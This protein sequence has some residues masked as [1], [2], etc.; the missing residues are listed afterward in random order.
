[1]FS[2]PIM[3]NAHAKELLSDIFDDGEIVRECFEPSELCHSTRLDEWGKLKNEL[4][5]KNR[6]FPQI[7]I[8]DDDR[9]EELLKNLLLDSEEEIGTWYRACIQRSESI[10]PIEEMNAPPKRL[11]SLGRAN[12]P[13]IPY[14]YLASTPD[15][16]I[17]EIRPHTGE[18]ATVADFTI[19]QKLNIVDLRNP[20][21]TVSPF[22]QKDED[23]IAL[24]RGDIEFLVH[25]G[26]EL[27][28]PVVPHAAAI[29]YI[30][31]QYICEF[32]KKCG[33][34]G[35]IYDSS[36]GSGVNIALFD[37]EVA[38]PG[39]VNRYCVTRVSVEVEK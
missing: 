7:K 2:H 14:L 31:S 3:D 18:F 11:A 19:S 32:I 24:L 30:P 8:N 37:P 17:S 12:P 13:G 21:R 38:T 34:H 4:M 27:T 36:V 15:T 1:M 16:A 23:E 6:F 35:V 33:Y 39:T 20:R 22:L 10:Y 25:L 26:N 5:H 9:L 29:D 28:R